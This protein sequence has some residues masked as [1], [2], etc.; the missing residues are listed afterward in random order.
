[1]VARK[2]DLNA[3]YKLEMPKSIKYK[4]NYPSR[5]CFNGLRKKH[6]RNPKVRRERKRYISEHN[7]IIKKHK[8]YV[9]N[10]EKVLALIHIEEI[11]Y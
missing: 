10:K 2:K 4:P 1:M 3:N 7:Q 11:I 9:R 6:N 8:K 5:K